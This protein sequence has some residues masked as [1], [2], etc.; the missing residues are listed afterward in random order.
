MDRYARSHYADQTLHRSA[1]TNA[2]RERT[3]MADLLADIAEIDGRQQYLPAGYPSMFA[4]CVGKLRL[5]EDAA[6]KRIQ[7]AR[8]AR[9]FPRA[10]GG[11]APASGRPQDQA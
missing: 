8:V 3:G 6:A 10:H 1:A 5:S 4:Y 9:R 11:P 7:A 2:G